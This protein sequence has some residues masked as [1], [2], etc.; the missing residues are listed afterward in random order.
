MGG[1]RTQSRR[2]TGIATACRAA[3][4]LAMA[5]SVL[6]TSGQQHQRKE[7]PQIATDS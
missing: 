6:R 4:P 3:T 7:Q 5:A 1:D 2:R